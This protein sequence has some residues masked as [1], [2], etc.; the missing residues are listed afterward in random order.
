MTSCFFLE[1]TPPMLKTVAT[2]RRAS[3][4][5]LDAHVV[6]FVCTTMERLIDCHR[7]GVEARPEYA[8]ANYSQ[9]SILAEEIRLARS[10]CS[11]LRS[12][13]GRTKMLKSV[14]SLQTIERFSL[15]NSAL[16]RCGGATNLLVMFDRKGRYHIIH[17]AAARL[18]VG[19][20]RMAKRSYVPRTVGHANCTLW[21]LHL[22][23]GL[24]PELKSR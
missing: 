13:Q 3:T 15:L 18:E 1:R 22:V 8:N 2:L 24:P 10:R 12:A 14:A 20:Q 9:S 7:W 4:P 5:T 6:K 23:A 11:C 19:L 21:L 17:I 16:K